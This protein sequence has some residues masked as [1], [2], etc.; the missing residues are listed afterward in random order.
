MNKI[1]RVEKYLF[2]FFENNIH[3]FDLFYR[4][5]N[6]QR[7]EGIYRL[8]N[9]NEILDFLFNVHSNIYENLKFKK[10]IP[11][12]FTT[13]NDLLVFLRNFK[14]Y[15]ENNSF[16]LDEENVNGRTSY[17]ITHFI[18][19]KNKIIKAI[20]YSFEIYDLQ[21]ENMLIYQ[22]LRHHLI[23]ENIELFIQNLKSIFSSVSY[24]IAKQS[25]GY[26]HA[27]VFLILKLLGFDIIPE[28]TTNIGRIDAVIKLSNRIYILEFKFSKDTDDSD[29]AYNQII[30]NEY[31]SKY[32]LENKPIYALGISFNEKVRNIRNYKFEKLN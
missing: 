26:F 25:E 3:D 18:E 21:D 31:A 20:D 16:L 13:P 27:N 17:V 14:K 29:K 32:L 10:L 19:Y 24:E 15:I 4:T 9:G 5:T 22:Q 12:R 7:N 2:D 1:E 8:E 28:D 11:S 30:E 23:T 6:E